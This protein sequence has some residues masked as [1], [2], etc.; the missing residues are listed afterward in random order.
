MATL[1]EIIQRFWITPEAAEWIPKTDVVPLSELREW[2]TSKDV[3]VLGFAAAM[4]NDARFRVD[5]PL[6]VDQYASFQ[7]HYIGRCFR[8]DPDGEWSDSAYS[9][10]WDLVRVYIHLWEDDRVPRS[11]LRDIKLW[12]ADIYRGADEKL[13]LCV[14]H[15]TLEHLFE[16]EPIRQF[17]RD[18]L[19]EPVLARAYKQGALWDGK[20][21]LTK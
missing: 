5:P 14:V 4:I 1:D 17:F 2:M 11:I 9:A 8:E 20:T 6:S 21:P 13:R 7:M 16:R 12:L 3:E 18:W 15:A 10:G 19:D